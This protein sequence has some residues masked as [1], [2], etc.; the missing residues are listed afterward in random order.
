MTGG[1]VLEASPLCRHSLCTCSSHDQG[2]RCLEGLPP[3]AGRKSNQNW[4][5]AQ[6]SI[7]QTLKVTKSKLFT[8][9]QP[10]AFGCNQQTLL[11]SFPYHTSDETASVYTSSSLKH[12]VH[13]FDSFATIVDTL[14]T[15]ALAA[16]IMEPA[17]LGSTHGLAGY[18]T[19]MYGHAVIKV[20]HSTH[21]F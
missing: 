2:C 9:S 16:G 5:S 11:N 14:W 13:T 3:A 6:S 18:F 12:A 8:S 4:K 10:A 1:F 20:N 19:L 21:V 17:I 15:N 7:C